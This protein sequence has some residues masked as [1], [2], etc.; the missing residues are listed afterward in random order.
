MGKDSNLR[1][2]RQRIYSPTPL[3]TREPIQNKTSVEINRGKARNEI[4]TRGP[5]LG[6]A[7]LYHWAIRAYYAVEGTW[8]PTQF[9][10]T[11]SLV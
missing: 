7:M 2:L 9:T 5:R 3:A 1:S 8:T 6:K 10:R 4:R 11:R